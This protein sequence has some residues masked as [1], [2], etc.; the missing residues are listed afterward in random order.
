MIDRMARAGTDASTKGEDL[1]A[2]AAALARAVALDPANAQ[3][4]SDKAYAESLIALARPAD[5]LALGAAVVADAD[6]ALAL[7]TVKAEFWIRRGTGL[8]MERRW[9]DGGDSYVRALQIAPM[10]A[11]VWY[12]RAYHLSLDPAQLEDALA[13]VD[14]CLRLDPGLLLAQSLRQRL[15]IRLQHSS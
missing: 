6:H 8:D 4:W 13:A 12:Y 7:C 14:V 3:A 5:T 2:A 1:S 10:R 15:A 9:L 11:D